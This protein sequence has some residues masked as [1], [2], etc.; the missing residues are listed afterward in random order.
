[1]FSSGGQ[2]EGQGCLRWDAAVVM[3]HQTMVQWRY[4]ILDQAF[5][6][7]DNQQLCYEYQHI[8]V[9]SSQELSRSIKT[10]RTY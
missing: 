2:Y 1:M 10:D 7:Y 4:A 8:S 6:S 3:F 5:G 9:L